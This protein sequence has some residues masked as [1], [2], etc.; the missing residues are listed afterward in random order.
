MIA[1]L[2]V[3]SCY[4]IANSFL[5]NT[6]YMAEPEND[7][8]LI[9]ALERWTGLSVSEVAR[10]SGL[11]PSTLTRP[12]N[13]PVKHRL[14]TPTLQKLRSTFPDFPAFRELPDQIPNVDDHEYF[15]VEV[16]PTYGGMGGGGTGEGDR[17]TALVPRQ[18]IER[19]LRGQPSDFRLINVRGN[20]MEP[21][22]HNGDQLLVDI[23]D[24]NPI[25]GGPFAIL[26]DGQYYVKNVER[27]P[28]KRGWY[29]VFSSNKDYSD[30]LVEEQ[31]YTIMGRPVWVGRRL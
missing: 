20:S 16:L 25:Q 5:A 9:E 12:L 22:F 21:L 26:D 27:A 23:R 6:A 2:Q 4:G 31:E 28:G 29:R 18:L 11:T 3:Q 13:Q 7:R 19:E 8:E 10:R 30:T 24:R 15:P 1:N 14:S 17:E